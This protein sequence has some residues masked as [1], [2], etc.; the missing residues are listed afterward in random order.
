[1]ET[2]V[3]HIRLELD[4]YETLQRVAGKCGLNSTALSVILL[5]ASIG[6]IAKNNERVPLPLELQV[7]AETVA[8]NEPRFKPAA[9][10]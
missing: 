6:A 7:R 1:M 2:R 8:P 9:R 5:K 3:I 10:R 4:G